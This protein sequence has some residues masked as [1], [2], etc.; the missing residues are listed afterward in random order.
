MPIQIPS[1]EGLLTAW[2]LCFLSKWPNH[3][4]IGSKTMWSR[5]EEGPS[6]VSYA[7]VHKYVTAYQSAQYIA[8]CICP[9]LNM[10]KFVWTFMHPH[11]TGNKIANCVAGKLPFGHIKGNRNCPY[12]LLL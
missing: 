8:C 2:V 6:P 4:A 9:Y 3:S 7:Q 11:C 12:R 10:L 1:G 5:G